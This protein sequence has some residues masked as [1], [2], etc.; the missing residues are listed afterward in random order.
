MGGNKT[1]PSDASVESFID[2]VA[3]ERRREDCRALVRM[4]SDISGC[5]PRI[6]GSM[7]GFGQYH[8][9]YASGREGDFFITG[10]APR[11]SALTVYVMSGLAGQAARLETLGPHRTGKSCLYLKSLDTVDTGVLREIIRDSV[12]TMRS[13]HPCSP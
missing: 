5:R 4:M 12:A 3:D 9:R 8:Y 6:W 2:S 7:I 13:R 1:R 11:Q 10:F